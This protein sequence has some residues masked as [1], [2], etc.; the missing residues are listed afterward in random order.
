L[1]KK[2]NAFKLIYKSLK[3]STTKYMDEVKLRSNAFEI[4]I[5]EE[6][7]MDK[8]FDIYRKYIYFLSQ[9]DPLLSLK[10]AEEALDL[11]VK[12]NNAFQQKV[13]L[14]IK[15]VCLIEFD[16]YEQ[17]ISIL[18]ECKKY[19]YSNKHLD[20]YSKTLTNLGV[21]Y[22]NLRCYNQSI[23][24]WKDVLINHIDRKDINYKNIV[25]NNLVTAYL[26][27]YSPPDSVELQLKEILSYFEDNNLTKDQLYCD[28]VVNLTTYYRIKKRYLESIQLGLE[29]LEMSENKGFNK[30]KYEICFCLFNTFK[31]MDN[32]KKMI[33]YLKLALHY[34][35]K[36]KYTYLQ[37][38]IYNELYLYYKSKENYKEAF[39]NIEEFIHWQ[40]LKNESLNNSIK[41]INQFQFET[42]DAIN[43]NYLSQYIEKFSFDLERYIYIENINGDLVKLNIDNIVFVKSYMKMINIVFSD[44]SNEIFK[45]PLKSFL[46]LVQEK[47]LDNHLFFASNFRKHIV[48]LYWLSRFDKYDKKLVLTVFGSDYLF[49]L[50]RNQI[51]AIK[52]Y[53]SNSKKQ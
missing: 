26:K 7:I 3:N 23:F 25:T 28:V 45:I 39:L 32:E 1:D 44:S 43:A 4:Q 50:S 47:F 9:N 37:E 6:L 2:N 12:T 14:F 31:D 15:A 35:N 19:F 46:G 52:E 38:E 29:A 22:Y 8:K 51:N 5:N 17:S 33:F 24:I 27:T 13:M 48:N 36:H 34:S 30:L 20:F 41:I 10:K 42:T 40:N 16:K 18:L 53:L 11:A 21:I 49:D